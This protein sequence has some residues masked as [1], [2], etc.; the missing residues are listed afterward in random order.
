MPIYGSLQRVSKTGEGERSVRAAACV[1]VASS[2]GSEV[3]LQVPRRRSS[4]TQRG[5]V[6]TQC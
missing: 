4:E 5:M 3:R 1:L 2:F 6:S